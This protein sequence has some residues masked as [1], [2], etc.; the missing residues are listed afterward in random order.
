MEKVE[1]GVEMLR[2]VIKYAEL[3]AG[4]MGDLTPI[5]VF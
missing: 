3:I 1:R 5:N 2:R 4:W